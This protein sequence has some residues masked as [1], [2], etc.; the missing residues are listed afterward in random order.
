MVSGVKT[1]DNWLERERE[2]G[3][4][5]EERERERERESVKAIKIQSPAILM[6]ESFSSKDSFQW[7]LQIWGLTVQQNFLRI[8]FSLSIANRHTL[9]PSMYVHV[10]VCVRMGVCATVTKFSPADWMF[11]SLTLPTWAKLQEVMSDT[12]GKRVFAERGC[13]LHFF[14]NLG[15][16]S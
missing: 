6:N 15:A 16:I 9:S 4:E 1:V 10:R 11:Q 8:F 12:V 3:A 2:G 5:N 7:L 14:A 13:Q